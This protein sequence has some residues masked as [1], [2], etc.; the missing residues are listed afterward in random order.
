MNISAKP[1]AEFRVHGNRLDKGQTKNLGRTLV[2]RRKVVMTVVVA[3]IFC[4]GFVWSA[5]QNQAM[6]P[7]FEG[8]QMRERNRLQYGSCITVATAYE[9]E[10]PVQSQVRLKDCTDDGDQD[11]DRDR[12]QLREGTCDGEP[13]TEPSRARDRL[14]DGSCQD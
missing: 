7:D 1:L 13:E 11:R 10:T 5:N 3:L 4:A 6:G 12:D 14:K 9:V 2:S 8:S